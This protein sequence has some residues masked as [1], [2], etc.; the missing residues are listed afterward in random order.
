VS[1]GSPSVGLKDV[2]WD[3]NSSNFG[4]GQDYSDAAVIYKWKVH[5]QQH[6]RIATLYGQDDNVSDLLICPG[7]LFKE[8]HYLTRFTR[9]SAGKYTPPIDTVRVYVVNVQHELSTAQNISVMLDLSKAKNLYFYD[10]NNSQQLPSGT[11][12]GGGQGSYVDFL[13]AVDTT[14]FKKLGE[15]DTDQISGR[16]LINNIPQ[17]GDSGFICPFDIIVPGAPKPTPDILAPIV[18][19]NTQT[20]YNTTWN[21]RDNRPYDTG[22]DSV[23]AT[24]NTNYTV[25]VAPF[26]RCDT[27]QRVAISAKVIDTSLSA[28]VTIRVVD[29]AGNDTVFTLCFT[30]RIDSLPPLVTLDSLTGQFPGSDSCN[31]RC[32]YYTAADNRPT[33]YGMG[34]LQAINATNFGAIVIDNGSAIHA[35]D[36]KATFSMCI[37]DSMFNAHADV[38]AKDFVGNT[39][40]TSV[41][42]CS[43]K[44]ATAPVI[45]ITKGVAPKT[46]NVKVTEI[47]AWDRGLSNVTLDPSSVNVKTIPAAITWTKDSSTFIVAAIDTFNTASFTICAQDSFFTASPTNKQLYYTSDPNQHQTC[48]SG[49]FS[50]NDTIPPN[51]IVTQLTPTSARVQVNDIHIV[52]GSRYL[53]DKGVESIVVD[54]S[55]V[56]I[57]SMFAPPN[58]DTALFFRIKVRDTL[59]FCDT[60]A[61]ARIIA[62]DCAFNADTLTW[63]YKIIPDTNAPVVIGTIQNGVMNVTVSDAKAYDRGLGNIDLSNLVNVSP[64]SSDKCDGRQNEQF[65]INIINPALNASGTLTVTDRTGVCCNLPLKG[66]HTT[67]IKFGTGATSLKF[68]GGTVFEN[69]AISVPLANT[70]SFTNLNI[71]KV[72]FQVHFDSTSLAF[73]PGASLNSPIATVNPLGIGTLDVTLS[74]ASGITDADALPS[75][76]LVG[77]Y[78]A[79]DSVVAPITISNVVVN[80]GTASKSFSADNNS[81]L[82]V[83]PPSILIDSGSVTVQ[84]RCERTGSSSTFGLAQNYPNPFGG[85]T[86]ITYSIP[87]NGHVRLSVYNIFGEEVAQLINTDQ[88]QGQYTVCFASGQLHGGTYFYKLDAQCQSCGHEQVAMQRMVIAR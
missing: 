17:M 48:K 51:I 8:V 29:C 13:L 81:Y 75:I 32:F 74:K 77:L 55:D 35:Q 41:D 69:D 12:L 52:N 11:N 63:S 80:G 7:N 53:L 25:T 39:D 44:D 47:Q 37:I 49:N 43:I 72:E 6:S 30:P 15:V 60:L 61:Y 42:Y 84:K 36:P 87:D 57:D 33:D 73:L 26:T 38:I 46:F 83:P 68:N 59:A 82:L 2:S 71:T 50:G 16:V 66:N 31:N 21:A 85:K 22:V 3:V 54:T 65:N 58:C 1:S 78:L 18:Q 67:V 56:I 9:D 45:T 34:S 70:G 88:T 19:Y 76:P 64:Y 14:T 86:Y 79:S 27:S 24:N 28:C 40:T 23:V 20:R 4:G 5:N 10:G 62:T